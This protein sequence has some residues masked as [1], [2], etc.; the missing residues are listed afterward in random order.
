M[1]TYGIVMFGLAVL[2]LAPASLWRPVA[3]ALL[4]Q[5][6]AAEAIYQATGDFT[7]TTV[8][9]IG[10]FIVVAAVLFRRSHWSDWF[11]VA[12]YPVVW[13]LYGQPE[14]RGQW[15]AL[16][17]IAIGQFVLAGPW[18]NII[19]ALGSFSH[20]PSKRPQEV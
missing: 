18:P 16:Y 10:D 14:T 11:I 9:L 8:Y 17:Y 4:V 5:W 3:T 7:P 2:W 15:E 1:S 6:A 19:K 13:W 20:G 12:P